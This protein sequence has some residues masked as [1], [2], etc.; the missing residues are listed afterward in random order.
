V[1]RIVPRIG[2]A[3]FEHQIVERRIRLRNGILEEPGIPGEERLSRLDP[4]PASTPAMIQE[5]IRADQQRLLGVW[6]VISGAV[7]GRPG[8]AEANVR[9]TLDGERIVVEM[10]NRWVG[11]WTV[12]PTRSPKRIN[13]VATSSGGA[14]ADVV[15]GVYE[16]RGDTLCVCLAFGDEPRPENLTS[17]QNTSQVSLA[18]KR[19]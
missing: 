7:G 8:G 13:L 2:L 10:D 11:K 9:W 3:G 15:R 12:D 19:Q 17:G 6:R 18:L 5:A 16:I 1:L 4:R 14:T